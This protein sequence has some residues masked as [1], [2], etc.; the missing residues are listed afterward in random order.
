[1]PKITFLGNAGWI[2][3]AA[4]VIFL[5]YKKYKRTGIEL[6]CGLLSCLIIGNIFLKNLVARER[7][8]WIR[9]L[10][11]MLVSVPLDYSFPSGHTL[12]SFAAAVIIMRSNKKAGF[13]AMLLAVLIA[14][15]RLYLYVHFPSDVLAGALLGT[16][17]GLVVCESSK[18]IIHKAD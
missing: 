13:A 7:P 15:S 1:M 10:P 5:I 3:I 14:F 4:A 11:D 12:S 8:C 6:V 16:A 9:E 18:R 17:I 2:W